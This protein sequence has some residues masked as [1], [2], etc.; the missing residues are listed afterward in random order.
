MAPVK[1]FFFLAYSLPIDSFVHVQNA[2]SLFS[3]YYPI[4][5]PIQPLLLAN[6]YPSF[7]VSVCVWPT[8][9]NKGCLKEQ[10]WRLFCWSIDSGH[11]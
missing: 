8:E 7:H 10:G 9:L 6:M 3:L 4:L 11:G 5:P 2:F 1:E